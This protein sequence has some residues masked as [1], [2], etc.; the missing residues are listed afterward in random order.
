VADDQPLS[1]DGEALELLSVRIDGQLVSHDRLHRDDNSLRIDA[2]PAVFVLETQVAIAPQANTELSGL[3]VSN[4][5]FFTQCEAEGFRRITY[6]PDRPDVMARYRVQ[7]VADASRWPVLLS[8]GN[9]LGTEAL[10]DG[11]TRA[12]WEDPFPK[13]SY[14]ANQSTQYY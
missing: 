2:P 6:F 14:L 5:N 11:R 7:I 9:L 8:N 13:P 4:G 3:Y 12:R 10:P 1:L